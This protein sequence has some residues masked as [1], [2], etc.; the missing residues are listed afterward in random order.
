MDFPSVMATLLDLPDTFRQQGP[1]YTQF[2]DSLAA[3]LSLYTLGNDATFSQVTAF[4]NAIDGWLDIWGLLFGIP[5]D[6]NEANALYR[7]AIQSTVLAW[8]GTVPAIQAWM[9][10]FAPGGFVV[11]NTGGVGYVLLFSGGTTLVQ[12]QAFLRLFNRIRPNG[13]PFQIQQAGLGL[14]LGTEEYLG[15]GRVVGNYLTSLNSSVAFSLSASTPNAAPLLSD[16]LL[17][18]PILNV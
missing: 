5:R 12:I 7:L 3:S 15:D 1:P 11:E 8:V 17:N 18:A 16:F 2:I 9:N 14:Y 6:Q 4:S 13:V 10:L